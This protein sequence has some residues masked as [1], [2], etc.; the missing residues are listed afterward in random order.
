[1]S[2]LCRSCRERRKTLIVAAHDNYA[3]HSP[4]AIFEMRAGILIAHIRPSELHVARDR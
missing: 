3:M 4:D 1:M 2:L